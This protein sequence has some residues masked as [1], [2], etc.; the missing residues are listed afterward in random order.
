MKFPNTV[1]KNTYKAYIVTDGNPLASQ[2]GVHV[3]RSTDLEWD[4]HYPETLRTLCIKKIAKCWPEQPIFREIT[5][6][7]DRNYLLDIID[8][9][10]PIKDLAA[11]I[12]ED[13]FWKR[14]FRNRWSNY[15]PPVIQ[16]PWINVFMEKY[17][18]ETIEQMAP[19]E[20]VE[21]DVLAVLEVCG[22]Y[23]ECLRI[24]QLQPAMDEQNDHIPLNFVLSNMSQLREIDITYDLKSIGTQFFLGCSNISK[25][26]IKWLASGLE[27]CYELQVFR[28]I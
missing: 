15:Y 11:H 7:E 16:R 23:L 10:T 8:V 14:C 17:I 21:D 22:P 4:T 28:Y 19:S 1:S 27:K 26:D 25:N 6:I 5:D 2:K 13:V 24:N 20:Y 18:A 3:L 9:D 12:Q